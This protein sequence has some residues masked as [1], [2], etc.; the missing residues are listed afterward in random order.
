ME[1]GTMSESDIDLDDALE[2]AVQAARGAGEIIRN[3]F[4]IGIQDQVK[5]ETDPV[6][7]TDYACEA[8][9]FKA[10]KARFP[11]FEFLGEESH[12]GEGSKDG[13]NMTDAPTWVCDP[14]DGT[15][16]FLHGVAWTCVSIGLVV[17][18][19]PVLGVVYNPISEEMFTAVRGKGARLNGDLIKGADQQQLSK[20]MICTEFG[21]NR[22]PQVL[23]LKLSVV[24]KVVAAPVQAVAQTLN[25][26]YATPI[27]CYHPQRLLPPLK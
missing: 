2:V 12:D 18:K 21:A 19:T 9:V 11:T 10:V 27:H 17:S 5:T 22:D 6:T 1:S 15:A 20:A 4:R 14:V 16:N 25:S 23:D 8:L 26:H 3:T 24:G 7:A 13:Y